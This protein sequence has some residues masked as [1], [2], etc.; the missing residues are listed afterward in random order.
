ME[1]I[2]ST[3][4]RALDNVIDLNFYPTPYAKLTNQKYRSIGLGVSGYHHMLAKHGIIWESEEHLKFAD[5]VFETINYAAIL[6]STNL[7]EEKESY[8][9]FNGSDWQSGAYFEKETIIQKNGLPCKKVA[10]QGMRNAY[11]LAVAPT[12]STS[13]I[14]GTTA[15]LDPILKRYFLEEKKAV[16]SRESHRNCHRLL[17]GITKTPI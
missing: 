16:C 2:V 1:E 9:L 8:S 7:A 15:G 13:I 11:L 17:T 5:T 14:S 4:V 6:A 10:T 3:A 12:S